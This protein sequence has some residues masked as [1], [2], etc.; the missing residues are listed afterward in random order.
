MCRNKCKELIAF[1]FNYGRFQEIVGYRTTYGCYTHSLLRCSALA[2]LSRYEVFNIV[3]TL[4]TLLPIRSLTVQYSFVP[5]E[6]EI[7]RMINIV[8]LSSLT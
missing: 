7:S 5:L 2:Q 3:N 1:V 6:V 8:L 4:K